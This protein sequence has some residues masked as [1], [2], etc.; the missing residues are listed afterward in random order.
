[1]EILGCQSLATVCGE[2]WNAFIH[3][4][5]QVSY[6]YRENIPNWKPIKKPWQILVITCEILLLFLIAAQMQS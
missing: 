1:M 4:L 5:I 6:V 3:F 2:G